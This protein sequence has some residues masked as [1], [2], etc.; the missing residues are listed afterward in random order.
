MVLRNVAVK[1]FISN[2]ANKNLVCFG[3]RGGNLKNFCRLFPKYEIEKRISSF[4]D[5]KE[6][7]WGKTTTLN[8]TE[9]PIF[10]PEKLFNEADS[11]TAILIN[12]WNSFNEIY[13]QLNRVHKLKDA[14]CYQ[15]QFLTDMEHRCRHQSILT[16]CR[17]NYKQVIPK[18]IHYFWFGDKPIPERHK[19]FIGSWRL[20]CPDYD[21]IEWNES[22]YDVSK[23]LYT[24]EAAL[25]NR[26]SK[27]ATYARLDVVYNYGGICMDTDVEMFKSLDELLYNDAFIGFE[28]EYG[29]FRIN[30]GS[31]FG[32]VK[33]FPLFYEMRENYDG[34]LF[35]S[36]GS[37]NLAYN[38]SFETKFMLKRG[39]SQDGHLQRLGKLTIYPPECFAPKPSYVFTNNGKLYVSENTF[40]VHHYD[41]TLVG[42]DQKT[43]KHLMG[44]YYEQ[45]LLNEKKRE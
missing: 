41:T 11:N 1:E 15:L 45:A 18:I 32:A 10:R 21:I 28:S 2:V 16:S 17:A 39:L 38:S 5:N 44:N 23:F 43:L 31:G 33:E 4:Y 20:H 13:E 35:N 12:S 34:T 25:A 6:N 42:N 30:A 14:E 9:I 36:D 24:K 8:D 40:T 19:L 22:N 7:L 29:E 26:W 3:A 37:P 27:V